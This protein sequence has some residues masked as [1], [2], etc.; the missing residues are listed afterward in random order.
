M[1]GAPAGSD[2]RDSCPWQASTKL[3]SET[4]NGDAVLAVHVQPGARRTEVVGRHGDALQVQVQAPA[5]K[6]KANAAVVTLLAATFGVP[7]SAVVLVRGTSSAPSGSGWW[8]CRPPPPGPARR[9]DQR[10]VGPAALVPA[11]VQLSS[12][13]G[14]LVRECPLRCEPTARPPRPDPYAGVVTG[15]K[16]LVVVAYLDEPPFGTG[17]AARP[18]GCDMDLAHHVLGTIGVAQVDY[19]LT[20]FPELIPA[21]SMGGGT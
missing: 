6:G 20:T 11:V 2:G 21:C 13:P 3:V 15:W 17:R 19:E 16:E 18:S 4:A 5:D 7:D 12:C 10:A 9:G 14:E 8:A 1:R